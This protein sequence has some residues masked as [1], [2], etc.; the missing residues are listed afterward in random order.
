MEKGW[1]EFSGLTGY[2]LE[3]LIYILFFESW[4]NNKK[5]FYKKIY[6]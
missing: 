6:F 2:T 4:L 1:I 3:D 5:Y